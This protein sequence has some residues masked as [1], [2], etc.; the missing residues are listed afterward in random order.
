MKKYT[1][2][3]DES[4]N[5]KEAAK[6]PMPSIVAGLL[7]EVD[8]S[9]EL[10]ARECLKKVKGRNPEYSSIDIRAFHAMEETNT[11]KADF[12]HEILIKP[13]G[14]SVDC[15][16]IDSEEYVNEMEY[17]YKFISGKEKSINPPSL[18]LKT[19]RI[20]IGEVK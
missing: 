4:G 9:N 11:Y 12:I 10:W 1:L 8:S 7:L 13:N 20:A 17:F 18:A 2:L 3:L 5:F 6:N 14:E 16:T 15:H 19:L